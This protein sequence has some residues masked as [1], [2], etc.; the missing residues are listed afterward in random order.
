MVILTLPA[1]GGAPNGYIE[2]GKWTIPENFKAIIK[3]LE[4]SFKG[5]TYQPEIW[6][7]E[8]MSFYGVAKARCEFPGCAIGIALR[9]NKRGEA[10]HA[11]I[12][13]WDIGPNTT[14]IYCDPAYGGKISGPDGFDPDVIIP[15]PTEKRWGIQI[16]QPLPLDKM[17]A[18]DGLGLAL[19]T[20]YNFSNF[21]K[22]KADIIAKNV[23]DCPPPKDEIRR[24]RY[25]DKEGRFY[26]FR[27]R[28]FYWFTQLKKTHKGSAIGVA[29][30]AVKK[31]G[32]DIETARL[33]LWKNSA[34][35]TYWHVD[36]GDKQD[37]PLFTPRIVLA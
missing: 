24:K 10:G 20:E 18:L 11:Q 17:T 23:E 35:Y 5:Q 13:L 36:K 4:D 3:Y 26:T 9:G 31:D 30:G 22:I 28:T 1:T 29:F 37:D 7:C 12:I 6:D 25:Y 19:D 15:F 33:V 32:Q 16:P 2:M 34:D 27:D 8:D 14:Y 21:E